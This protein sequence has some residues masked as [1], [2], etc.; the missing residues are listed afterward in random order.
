MKIVYF[1]HSLASCWNHGNAHFLRGV[2]RELMALGHEVAAYEPA[3]A[4]SLDN[5]LSDHGSEGLAAFKAAYPELQST[6]IDPAADPAPLVDGADLVIVHEWNAPGLV[7][8]L[9]RLRNQGGRFTLLFHD[10]HHRA[11]SEPEAMRAF[12]LSGYDGVLAFGETLAEV[13]R[14]WGWGGRVFVWHEAA[15]TRLFH[16]PEQ[17]GPRDGLVWIGNWG[18]GERS[19]ELEEYLFR[20]ARTAQLSLDV[21]GVRYPPEAR[22]LLD[23][24]GAAFRGW[25]PN[26]QAPQVYARHLATVHVPRRFYTEMLPGIPTIRVFEALACGIPLV[27]APWRDSESLF[28]PGDDYLVARNGTEMA[29]HLRALRHEP[30]LRARLVDNGLRA[31]CARHSCAHRAVELLQILETLTVQ[32]PMKVPA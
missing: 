21:Y 6:A 16:P 1:T 9:G 14:G 32:A 28:R 18:D 7:A 11:V 13:Y 10:T 30:D 25:L 8:A 23:A 20:P 19:A 3:G 31:I 17:E 26:A 24:Y 5:L 29:H 22:R 12:D 4:W 27:C 2:L 15:D